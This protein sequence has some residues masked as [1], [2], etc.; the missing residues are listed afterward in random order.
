VEEDLKLRLGMPIRMVLCT[1][2]DIHRLINKHYPREV[3]DAELARRGVRAEDSQPTGLGK[4]WAR[5]KKWVE[6]NNK[7][8]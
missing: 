4:V 1:V 8:K 2:S 5:V 7:K 6:E 3:A